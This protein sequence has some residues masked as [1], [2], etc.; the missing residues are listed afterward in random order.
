MVTNDVAGRLEYLWKVLV[1]EPPKELV[2]SENEEPT[3]IDA[4][5]PPTLL[6]STGVPILFQPMSTSELSKYN[7]MA[8]G[9]PMVRD[10]DPAKADED[11]DLQKCSILS[12]GFYFLQWVFSAMCQ[13][14][15]KENKTINGLLEHCK[16][17][18]IS[19]PDPF[20]L[21][22]NLHGAYPSIQDEWEP[23]L[24]LEPDRVDN[25]RIYPHVTIGLALSHP[26]KETSMLYGELVALVS[27]MRSRAI[28]PQVSDDEDEQE[29]LFNENREDIKCM[30]REF[31][32][33]TRFPVLLLS[34]PGPQHARYFYACM[35][36]TR[37][38][39][40]Q[41]KLY[42]F[43]NLGTAPIQLFMRLATSQPLSE[44]GRKD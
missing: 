29:A 25:C 6:R 7:F 34:C 44:A 9:Q 40:I 24:I 30:P 38:V 35:D 22:C 12:W 15:V 36:G 20:L 42:S 10:Y 2:D 18:P 26:G 23:N 43:E 33:E 21:G 14:E 17:R 41:S 31:A 3:E 39:I 32:N 27:A 5:G 28:Q 11:P 19:L 13:C 16:L 8:S 37:M 1:S 4:Y